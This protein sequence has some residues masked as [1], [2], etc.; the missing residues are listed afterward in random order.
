M[1]RLLFIL[2]LFTSVCY[3]NKYYLSPTGSDAGNGTIGSPY[4]TLNKVWTYV[5]AGDTVYLRGG[6]YS[7]NYQPY[8]TGKSGTSGNYINV[9]NYPGEQ[10]SFTRGGSY[11][12]N[13]GIYFSGNYLWFKGIE[14]YGFTQ[15]GYTNS[16]VA[17]ISYSCNYCIFENFNIH[18]C[19]TG[20]YLQGGSSSYGTCTGNLIIDSDFHHLVDPYTPAPNQFGN[21]S[22]ISI[23]RVQTGG[24]NTVRG[25]RFWQNADEGMDVFMN[26]GMVIID[27][28]WAWNIGYMPGIN[29]GDTDPDTLITASGCN[30]M[31]FKLG[32]MRIDHGDTVLRKITNCLV[33]RVKAHAFDWN[34]SSNLYCAAEIYN[35]TTYKINGYQGYAFNFP[36]GT[37]AHKVRNNV[38]Y[39]DYFSWHVHF[40][41][42]TIQDHNTW[43]PATGVTVSDAD[44]VSLDPGE[45]DNTRQND[46]SLP[47]INFMRPVP[48]SDLI[49]KGV[50]VGINYS[51]AAPDLGAFEIGYVS[52]RYKLLMY[53]GKLI[54]YNGQL[55]HY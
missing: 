11:P 4:L 50:Y 44:F 35:N 28:C 1:K 48:T 36:D 53:N 6:V 10:P 5:S 41:A 51:G 33:Y 21:S 39:I 37:Y 25:C 9:W 3:G 34:G 19:C 40:T 17:M 12:A 42:N 45:L 52:S 13:Y 7:L 43:N 55:L 22:G 38:T 31:G 20:L 49:D 18:H 16:V 8:L 14:I 2:L 29:V 27:R 15:V 54:I 47:E 23:N 32:G 30:G 24:I 46:G 26:D